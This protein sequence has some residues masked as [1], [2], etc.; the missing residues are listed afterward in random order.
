MRCTGALCLLDA[1]LLIKDG[2]GTISWIFEGSGGHH[3]RE[4][5]RAAVDIIS[6]GRLGHGR[7][8]FSFRAAVDIKAAPRTWDNIR[9]ILT[10][11][12]FLV[13]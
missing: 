3:G 11:A 13:R 4:F 12:R 10:P 1:T 2:G 7:V 9:A 8:F 6:R 5:L